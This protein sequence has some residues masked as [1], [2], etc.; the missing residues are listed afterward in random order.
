MYE[1]KVPIRVTKAFLPPMSEYMEEIKQLWETN[2]VT[3][4]GKLHG[5]LEENLRNYLGVKNATL[6][7]NGHSAL[8]IA[9]KSLNLSGEVITTPFTFAST[10]HA[11]VLNNLNL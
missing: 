4:N 8:D 11:I 5:R 7:T 6:F 1:F 2:W 10:T 3:N 9:I